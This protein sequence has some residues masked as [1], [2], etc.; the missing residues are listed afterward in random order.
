MLTLVD[1]SHGMT[2]SVRLDN[3]IVKLHAENPSKIDFVSYTNSVKGGIGCG[4]VNP[5]LHV[6]VVYRRSTDPAF[7]GEPLAVEFR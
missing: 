4:P 7:L 6:V 5:E 3:R 2:L 1:C